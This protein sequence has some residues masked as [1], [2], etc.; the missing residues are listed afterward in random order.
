MQQPVKS[1]QFPDSA[2]SFFLNKN[3]HHTIFGLDVSKTIPNLPNNADRPLHCKWAFRKIEVFLKIIYPLQN[4]AQNTISE[5]RFGDMYRRPGLLTITWRNWKFWVE[6]QMVCAL[7]SVRNCRL[8]FEA[9]QFLYFFWSGTRF[10]KVP[11]INGPGKL[12]P[13]TLKI[14]VLIVLHLT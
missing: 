5:W 14:K 11:I 12:S 6:N 4:S 7:E 13:F 2:D 1:K 10:L 3:C 9:M 8:S